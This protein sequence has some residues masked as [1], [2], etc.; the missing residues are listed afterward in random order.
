MFF[1]IDFCCCEQRSRQCVICSAVW[2]WAESVGWTCL[3]WYQVWCLHRELQQV[4]Y[5]S[6]RTN[7]RKSSHYWYRLLQR[8]V[9]TQLVCVFYRKL[10]IKCSSY[11]QAQW[12]SHEI[13]SFSERCDFHQ[14]HRFE[15][16]APPRPD[17][18]TKWCVHLHNMSLDVFIFK[19]YWLI[20]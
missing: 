6:L 12:W 2:P 5:W 20:D 14:T 10:V 16:F 17:T 3:H 7:I 18:L 9:Q 1:V 15:G 4:K 19:E 13:R 8:L 11:R